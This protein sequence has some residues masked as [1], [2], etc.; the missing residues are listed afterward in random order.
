[1]SRDIVRDNIEAYASDQARADWSAD[2]G[3]YPVER[4]IVE[5]FFPAAPAHIL[6]LGCGAGRTTLGLEAMGY[7]VDALDISE[8][9]VG[10]ARRRVQRSRVTLMD[11]RE[12]TF[13]DGTFDAA[14]F[15][16][17][18]L[19]C[20]HPSAERLRVIH[21]V[22]RVLRPGAIFYY[23]GHNGLGAWAPR[24]GDRAA[25]VLKRNLRLLRAQGTAFSER[26]R[27]LAYPDPTGTQV[28]YSAPP[29]VHVRE[30]V[31][32]GFQ[33]LEVWAARGASFRTSASATR[34]E[35]ADRSMATMAQMLRL[36]LVHPHVH[37]IARRGE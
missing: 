31:G 3:L 29:Q 22:H 20:L 1:M 35:L 21:E 4:E 12:L 8:N 32:A 26:S 11:A 14:L 19:D 33:P 30:L 5:A 10:E 37:Y 13:A 15:S 6:D 28:L 24:P 27:Y 18:G 2:S 7:D 36:T 17:N 9:L 16:F 25:R 34:I 23:S